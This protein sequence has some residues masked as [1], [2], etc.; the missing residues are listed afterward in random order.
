MISYLFMPIRQAVL[1]NN[2]SHLPD[3]I[4]FRLVPVA[5][6]VDPFVDSRFAEKVVASANAPLEAQSFQQCAELLEADIRVGGA[7]QNSLQRPVHTHAAILARSNGALRSNADLS[8]FTAVGEKLGLE[9]KP[10][11]EPIEVL[12][13]DHVENPDAN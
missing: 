12:V 9:Q 6:E 5:L 7:A 11:K 1:Q 4:R 10:P 8:V 2:S 13:I 3:L